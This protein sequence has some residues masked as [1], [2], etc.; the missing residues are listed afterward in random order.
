[1]IMTS[2]R[3]KTAQL[4]SAR[5]RLRKP[6]SR[7][8]DSQTPAISSAS[9]EFDYRIILVAAGVFIVHFIV[10]SLVR[11]GHPF[12]F[13]VL[14]GMS[15]HIFCDG[16]GNAYNKDWWVTVGSPVG[17]SNYLPVFQYMLYAFTLTQD[18]L[19]GLVANFY[20]FKS[21]VLV[22]DV[23]TC[24][25]LMMF[26]KSRSSSRHIIFY[27]L[28]YGLNFFYFY[29][30]DIWGQFD[31]VWVFF[32]FAMIFHLLR[33]EMLPFLF[34]TVLSINFKPQI[35]I[36]MPIV[37]LLFLD[38]LTE[39]YSHR[40]LAL[41][42]SFV[43]VVQ[44]VILIPFLNRL[45]LIWD[46]ITSYTNLTPVISVHAF[47]FWL[48][49]LDLHRA[50]SL[51][52]GL[53][54]GPV[55]YRQFGLAAFALLYLIT[56]LPLLQHYY[57][58]YAFRLFR[59]DSEAGN[60]IDA[61]GEFDVRTLFLILTLVPLVCFFFNTEMHSRYTHSA[62][63]FLVGYFI[64]T[65]NMSSLISYILMSVAYF[66]NMEYSA[67][68]LKLDKSIYSIITP[69]IIACL[70]LLTIVIL[71]FELYKGRILELANNESPPVASRRAS[72]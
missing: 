23:L 64:L 38:T 24:V 32:L 43:V 13:R 60:A 14:M 6:A 33:K 20:L 59:R 28:F 67:G 70:Y 10:I 66:L 15:A 34:F 11:E 55:T 21:F 48:M 53:F 56:I 36:F 71:L 7:K 69:R 19:R 50:S 54:I 35:I 47:N 65:R 5:K 49:V 52:S 25:Y 46:C 3:S 1:M 63:I 26:V 41:W 16:I 51:D 37:F 57:R 22:F 31:S 4:K 68:V 42:A 44:F 29:N 30:T 61:E 62:F 8:T 12:D 27:S 9:G 72:L 17:F 18:S 58:K 39:K 45:D 40:N 2:S